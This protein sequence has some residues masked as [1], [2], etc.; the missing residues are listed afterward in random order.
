MAYGILISEESE[1]DESRRTT[2]STSPRHSLATPS[3]YGGDDL[4]QNHITLT[5]NESDV[6]SIDSGGEYLRVFFPSFFQKHE[7][8]F[9]EALSRDFFK[10]KHYEVIVAM[11]SLIIVS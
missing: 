11:T 10:Q 5:T 8:A 3:S 9:L 2:P 7:A 1:N 6:K 4:S